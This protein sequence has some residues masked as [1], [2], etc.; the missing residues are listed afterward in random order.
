MAETIFIFR[1]DT[2]RVEVS[3]TL[4]GVAFAIPLTATVRA[5]LRRRD[6]SIG[7]PWTCSSGF[8][9]ADWPAGLVVFEISGAESLAMAAQNLV[10]IEVEVNDAGKR[11]TWLSEP[12]L[13][14]S[15]QT[16]V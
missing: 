10:Q 15:E 13:Y 2:I 8:T 5:G 11:Q 3:L 1:G 9:G 6:V 4:D 14:V 16:I 7:G 12:L